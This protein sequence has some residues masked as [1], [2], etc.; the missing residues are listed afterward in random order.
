MV[1]CFCKGI[2]WDV[3][4][5]DIWEINDEH[6]LIGM[7]I[8]EDSDGQEDRPASPSWSLQQNSEEAVKMANE[9]LQNVYMGSGNTSPV[10][11][12]H[13][14]S[15]SEIVSRS[16]N[17]NSSFQS[18]KLQIQ[19][20]WRWGGNS[21]NDN[22]PFNFNPEVLAN[23]KR[24]WYQ[25]QSQTPDRTKYN[26]PTSLFE[27]FVVTGLHPDANIEAVK[28]DFS[29]KKKWEIEMA[30]SDRRECKSP[31]YH[32]PSSP[33]LEPKILFKYPPGKRLP[34]RSKDLCA[35]SFPGGVKARLVERTP[36]LS[37]LS[38]LVYGQ[39]HLVTDKLSFIFSVKAADNG[40]LYGVCLH[41]PEIVQRPPGILGSLSPLSQPPATFSRFF[42]SAAR[43]YC[44]L[45]RVPFFELHYE[46]LNSIIAQERLNRITQFVSEISLN[47]ESPLSFRMQDQ[48]NGNVD[49]PNR[50][51]ITD[52]TSP[53]ISLDSATIMSSSSK[54]SEYQSSPVVI[55]SEASEFGPERNIDK[56]GQ[57]NVQY[58]EDNAS[59]T[60][61]M[62]PNG[63]ER[64]YENGISS[65]EAMAPS[66][67]SHKMERSSSS[68]SLFSPV[69]SMESQDEDYEY[70]SNYDSDSGE[71]FTM[72]W[73]K[74]YR[75]DFLQIVC[76]YSSQP[77]PPRGGEIVFQPLEHLQA[78]QYMRPPVTVLGIDEKL[79]YQEL[80]DPL[81]SAEVKAKLAAAEEAF[82]LSVW[83]TATICRV[84]S[85]ESVLALVSGVLLEKQV[86]VVSPNLGILSASVLSVVPMIR[87]FEWQS[88]LLPVLPE[89]MLDFLDA[90]VP[91]IVGIQDKPADLKMKTSN[92]IYIN[93]LK[94]QAKMCYLPML[95]RRKELVAELRP[96]HARLSCQ[97]SIAQ[98]HPVYRCNELQAEAAMQFLDVMRRYMES[99]CS[100]LRSYTITSVQSNNDRVSLLL[101]ESY[102]DSF[103][104]RDRPFIKLFVDTQMFT[105]LSDSRLSC[106]EH[107]NM[108]R[109]KQSNF[110]IH[111][112]VASQAI[113]SF[114]E[115]RLKPMDAEQLR[116]YGH[117]MVDF[118]ADYYKTIENFPVL[119]QVQPGYLCKLIP[120]SAP[121]HP[122]SLEDVLDDVR[123]KILPGVTHWQSPE[124][125]AYFPSNS[126][127][128]GF[129]GE[130]LSAG[131]NI[132]GFSWVTSPAATE[133]EMI[134]LD[135]LAK[136]LKL[137]EDFLSLKCGG[138]VIQGT[139][140]EAALVVLLAARDKV[141]RK[142]GND[143]LR[144]LVVY[145]SDQAHSC[146]Q[147]ACQIAGIYPK[148][149]RMVKTD[150]STNYALSPDVLSEAISED[151]AAG[152]IPVLLCATVGT[153]SSATVDP[154]LPLGKI[155]KSNRMWFHV[156]AAYAGSACI[157]PE[158]RQ[159]IDGVE[160]ADSFTMNAHKWLLTNFDCSALWVKDRSAL[161]QSLS[162]DPEFLKNKA[163]ETK[164]VVDYKDWQIPLGRRFRSL[165]L[166]IILRLYG[167]EGLQS[168]IRNHIMLAKQFEDL[169]HQDARFEVVAP[170]N[171]SLVCFRLVPPND[172][173][174][175]GNKLNRSL[176]EAVNSTGKIFIS[177]TV[178]SNKYVLCF[179]VGAPLTEERHINAAWKDCTSKK[180]VHLFF[181]NVVKYWDLPWSIV[182]DCDPRLTRKF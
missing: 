73:A 171:F 134:V 65:L 79:L 13:R 154:L 77:I 119:S 99:L 87:P 36:S 157:C 57:K 51:S 47:V 126:S 71:F 100:D 135:W 145:A 123:E 42:V 168:Y 164:M 78:I 56:H 167:Q 25:L 138:G 151:V 18:I 165:K 93:V 81:K 84:L 118:V 14:R 53:A 105:V 8:K 127:T 66:S 74:E 95:P 175:Y 89:K 1:L 179:A 63:F 132:V 44:L 143:S 29:R 46:M 98:K 48:V 176:L 17:R 153:T 82:A 2:Q 137:P 111:K 30:R 117:Q 178:L 52:W 9:A 170:R 149:C 113:M 144:K 136:I 156:D 10:L 20:A 91:Y 31:Q 174:N 101:K 159:Y 32:M 75:N 128:A 55:A 115:D 60:S 104:S 114:R 37:D 160:E 3:A 23:Q 24:Q 62:S 85:L 69:R 146:I 94:D 125:F 35:F 96:I 43:C 22:R 161:T 39:E 180:A 68:A 109:S 103:Q 15:H 130:M 150:P 177:H 67:D 27:H 116:E 33:S 5:S 148:N 112:S 129:L 40:T 102:I 59:H 147:K 28:D 131:I 12:G 173:E 166:W 11:M 92:L 142:V 141:L 70:F 139:A 16:H 64:S 21:E 162:T 124:Y 181:K 182:S 80:K 155:A 41:V 152:L 45:T 169:V 72:E 133:L 88:L 83:T 107:E 120:D 34:M 140:S 90:P 19:R 26:D 106:F 158:Y 4:G 110:Y 58:F 49:S 86:V 97:N 7:E 54:N 50:E 163:S 172:D 6:H 38:K 108:E 76:G 61:E 122:E 121:V